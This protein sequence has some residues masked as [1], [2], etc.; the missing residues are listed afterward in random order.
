G[1]IRAQLIGNNGVVALVDLFHTLDPGDAARFATGYTVLTWGNPNPAAGVDPYL[2]DWVRVYR[3]LPLD[4]H[5]EYTYGFLYKPS[6]DDGHTDKAVIQ[7]IWI[8]HGSEGH[9]SSDRDERYD[10]QFG[11]CLKWTNSLTGTGPTVL[12]GDQDLED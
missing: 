4:L 5:G 12:V 9:V 6:F 7:K 10:I 3:F 11:S 8:G 1:S 2:L